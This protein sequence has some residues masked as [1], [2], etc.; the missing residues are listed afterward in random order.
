MMKKSLILK[1]KLKKYSVLIAAHQ[2]LGGGNIILNTIRGM[3]HAIRQ[4][5]DIIETD[6][7]RT[8]DGKFFVFHEDLEERHLMTKKKISE[9]TAA[10]LSE[11]NLVNSAFITTDER[12][13]TT[14]EFL[15]ALKGD[16]LINLDKC[17][18]Y[19]KEI[20]EHLDQFQMEH[21]FIIKGP[22][23]KDYLQC[24]MDHETKYMFMPIIRSM[25]E[26]KLM[27]K[28]DN[29]KINVI[30]Y[31][32]IFENIDDEHVKPEVLREL[33][34]QGYVLWVNAI[35]LGKG[36][37]LSADIDDDLSVLDDPDKGWG[38]LMDMGFDILQTDWTPL[39]KAY[40][41]KRD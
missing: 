24:F 26:L 33:K 35:T 12:V 21:Q 23:D 19:G 25:E 16:T 27:Q 29:D 10:E 36:F 8:S 2:G 4:G 3:Q 38:V 20:L 41:S 39:L 37:C 28:Y 30:G 32:I 13:S 11:L 14:E 40:R 22:V 15:S 7:A 18:N 17:W 34:D 9:M 1:E 6:I 5:A 31:E